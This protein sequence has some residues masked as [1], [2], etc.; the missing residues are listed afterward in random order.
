MVVF[1][2]QYH[3]ALENLIVLRLMRPLR[4]DALLG[5]I[6]QNMPDLSCECLARVGLRQELYPG[7]EPSAV[8]NGVLCVAGREEDGD[9]R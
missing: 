6:G 9:A 4:H 5:M 7:I 3:R 8:Y 2:K 1:D